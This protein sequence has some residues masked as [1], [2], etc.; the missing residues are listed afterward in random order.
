MTL[1]KWLAV[2]LSAAML[3]ALPPGAAAQAYPNKPIRLIVPYP[4][5]GGSDV[6][7]RAIAEKL[8]TALAVQ[9]VVDNRAGAGGNIAASVA[10]KAPADG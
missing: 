7:A 9:V 2:T 10:A 8:A 6:M 5:G 4:A 1:I 3:A